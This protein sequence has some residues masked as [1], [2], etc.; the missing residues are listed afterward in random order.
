MAETAVV[1]SPPQSAAAIPFVSNA[2]LTQLQTAADQTQAEQVRQSQ[3]I[4]PELETGLAGFIRTE[5]DTFK[6]HRNSAAGWSLRLLY[7]LRTFNGQYDP[8]LLAEIRKFRGSEAYIRVTS[9]K[10]RATSSLLRD[11]YL[12]T[13]R[14]WGL[15]APADPEIPIEALQAVQRKVMIETIDQE[16]H[17][18]PVPDD[19]IN[20]R[21]Q[22]LYEAVRD[23]VRKKAAARCRV[24]EDKIDDLLQQG[25]FYRA[26][27]EFLTDLPIFPFACI[28]G[29]VVK[30]KPKVVWTD[31]K[32]HTQNRPIITYQ[33][34]SPFDMWFTPGVSNIEDAAVIERIRYTRADIDALLDI[35]GYNHDAVRAVLEE[36]GRGGMSD[37]WDVVD[38]TR[39]VLE[40]REN[41]LWNRSRMIT[42]Y[43]YHGKVQGY[44]ALSAG[45][46]PE[47]IPDPV[48]E[49]AIQAWL[50]GRHII[51][52]QLAPSSSRRHPYYVTSFEKVPGT[53]VGNGLPDIMSDI[54]DG[55]NSTYRSLLN[56]QAMASGP[57]VVVMDD[58][59]AGTETG[60]D[61]Y[62]WKRWHTNSDPFASSAAQKPIDFF[63][64]NDNSQQL[65]ATLNALF[66]L[67][68][69][70]SAVP[71]YLQGSSPGAGA[72]RTASGMAM[73]MGNASKIL[74]TVA[75]NIDG[76]VMDPLLHGLLDLILLTDTTDILDGTESVVVKGVQVAIQR[77]TQRSRQLEF[78]QITANPIDM[79]IMGIPGRAKVLEA[80][81]KDLGIPGDDIIPSADQLEQQQQAQEEA[82]ANGQEP[83][84]PGQKPESQPGQPK[85]QNPAGSAAP[86][87]GGAMNQP[88]SRTALRAG[89]RV[90]AV[91]RQRQA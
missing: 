7:A 75:A 59:L 61:I 77:E 38:S 80:V 48:R 87:P 63:Q 47:L 72:G 66:A 42:G 62:P 14:P 74:Q 50:I 68:D 36:Y 41:P 16:R 30:I 13:E 40:N 33:R 81:S 34:I 28:K 4:S 21:T 29:P 69:D 89:P 31:G 45:V 86:S 49:Y 26:L 44:M 83:P 52:V 5:Y 51:K 3:E 71:R 58:R 53:V 64:P 82:A 67:G 1:P 2:Q 11:V 12:N 85:P 90:N 46:D 25:G 88:V 56:N 35:D 8:D 10:C 43:E 17:G 65:L 55:A 39:A 24:A 76:D 84:Q 57:Q 9:M 73:L 19:Q 15:N 54:Q 22:Q 91:G 32:P 78:L 79:Q 20:Q 37:D 23:G 27:Q 6:S 18:Q 60:D 70:V